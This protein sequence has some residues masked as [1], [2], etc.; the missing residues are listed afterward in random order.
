MFADPT[1]IPNK[2]CSRV[3]HTGGFVS[4]PGK[5][6]SQVHGRSS[7]K[8][9]TWGGVGKAYPAARGVARDTVG[10]VTDLISSLQ[11]T[12]R[13]IVYPLTPEKSERHPFFGART[14]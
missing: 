9:L 11:Q 10:S 5:N 12:C 7:Q 1:L 13:A 4:S 14:V 6:S 8:G 2:L 3:Q